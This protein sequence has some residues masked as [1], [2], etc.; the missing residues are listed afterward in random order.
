MSVLGPSWL[1]CFKTWH[2]HLPLHDRVWQ[3]THTVLGQ[4]HT[5]WSKV[6]LYSELD[7]SLI[8]HHCQPPFRWCIVHCWG[9]GYIR[10][11]DVNKIE[12]VVFCVHYFKVPWVLWKYLGTITN[13]YQ[14]MV[15]YTS[16]CHTKYAPWIKV[17]H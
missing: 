14:V 9:Q 4:C 17:T 13:Q 12:I 3:T 16:M 1:S 6:K 8:W 5:L 2:R 7:K 15:S 10:H 11:L